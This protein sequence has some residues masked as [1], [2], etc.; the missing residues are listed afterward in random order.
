MRLFVTSI[1]L[2]I[3]T[4]IILSGSFAIAD[5]KKG[6]AALNQRDAE[7]A[8]RE[9]RKADKAG[10]VEGTL[11]L[12][13][14]YING[15]GVPADVSHGTDLIRDVA[16]GG[17][18]KAEYAMGIAYWYGRGVERNNTTAFAWFQRAAK[19]QNVAAQMK[20]GYS[21]R[22]GTGVTAN[23]KKA[24]QYFTLA[25]KSQPQ[26]LM[27]IGA[28]YY[29]G[30]GV[31][32][33][34][35]KAVAMFRAGAEQD[36]PHSLYWLSYVYSTGEGVK[37]NDQKYLE[38]LERAAN[39]GSG[40]AQY[41]MGRQYV[42]VLG[43]GDTVKAVYWFEKAALSGYRDAKEKLSFMLERDWDVPTEKTKLFWKKT[44]ADAGV[45][46]QQWNYAQLLNRG[47]E[48][49][50]DL[51][52]SRKYLFASAN[53]G[54]KIAQFTVGQAYFEGNL[55]LP[56]DQEKGHQ[57]IRD[58]ALQSLPD[59][60]KAMAI[61][62]ESGVGA[63]EDVFVAYV[64]LLYAE[65]EGAKDLE[66]LRSKILKKLDGGYRS[67]ARKRLKSCYNLEYCTRSYNSY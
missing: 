27:E 45:A 60:M 34:L 53:G 59:A 39:L 64:W 55:G 3:T 61:I 20:L 25:A 33:N 18:A 5:V 36:H 11:Y 30:K 56:I 10:D 41:D 24:E 50:K 15:W 49:K 46:Q 28:M 6:L 66:N 38:Y 4:T 29:S 65:K 12:G 13:K 7:T 44:L 21:Y 22:D 51:E 47:E 52:L 8:F 40:R 43:D 32:K 37:A 16:E 19:Q 14:A 42:N 54:F 2:L 57:F 48:V 58:A 67:T 9:F 17:L 1:R 23:G 63:N 26:G 31:T 62:H 35:N